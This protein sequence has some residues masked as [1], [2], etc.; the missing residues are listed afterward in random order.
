MTSQRKIEANKRNAQK[1][2]GPKTAEGK[3]RVRLNALKHGLTATTVVL[4]HEDAEA[5]QKR[6]ETWTRELA[7]RGDVGHYLTER[8][9]RLSWQLDRA[10][11]HER[12]RL[13]ERVNRLSR[14]RK[15]AWKRN[16]KNVMCRLLNPP[17]R[18]EYGPGSPNFRGDRAVAAAQL[19]WE[20]DDPAALIG[21][22]EGSAEGCRRL[23]A[24]WRT[25]LQEVQAWID[26]D[27]TPNW[28]LED[29]NH[30]GRLFGFRREEVERV[31]KQNRR[32]AVILHAAKLAEAEEI[33]AYSDLIEDVDD[34]ED[35]E[36]SPDAPPPL[37]AVT[38]PSLEP[39]RLKREF[40]AILKEQCARLEDL[41]AAHEADPEDDDHTELAAF[42]DSVEGEWLH[43]Y[44]NHWSRSLL[45]TLDAIAKLREDGAQKAPDDRGA[46][47]QSCPTCD[48]EEAGLASC[49][50]RNKATA[51]TESH[52]HERTYAVA[53]QPG[54]SLGE[55]AE[56]RPQRCASDA[57]G[58]FLA[59][60]GSADP[61]SQRFGTT[62]V[63]KED[64]IQPAPAGSGVGPKGG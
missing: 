45:R 31:A 53:K 32:A 25:C 42:D 20:A 38:D 59:Q 5:Y 18:P 30:L 3:E 55:R 11:G 15:R 54:K 64:S 61:H 22:L 46:G 1:S 9:V 35:D 19:A 16:V 37:P 2:S 40:H 52:D 17:A 24:K 36:A 48:E 26:K 12:A 34:D 33:E 14:E 60:A 50:A 44:Q 4:P 6:L 63:V 49:P 39:A 8:A 13:A 62:L 28:G 7:P 57:G 23:L 27:V 56:R 41:L 29:H 43:R 21:E 51:T 58:P 10:D 47:C